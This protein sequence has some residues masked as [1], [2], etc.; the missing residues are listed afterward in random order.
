ML[1]KCYISLFLH[2]DVTQGEEEEGLREGGSLKE[3][4]EAH[5]L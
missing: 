1:T 3:K 2:P 4:A 5:G